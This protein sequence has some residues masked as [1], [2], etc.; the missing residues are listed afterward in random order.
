[1]VTLAPKQVDMRLRDYSNI[2][3]PRKEITGPAYLDQTPGSPP[4]DLLR[5]AHRSA[6]YNRGVNLQKAQSDEF[7]DR[8]W[9][10]PHEAPASNLAPQEIATNV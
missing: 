2:Q 9:R 1:M 10:Q 7:L 6:E 5:R 3:R 4:T 8:R